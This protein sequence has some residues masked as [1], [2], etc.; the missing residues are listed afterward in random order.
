MKSTTRSAAIARRVA[1]ALVA[2]AMLGASLV[3]CSSG[4]TTSSSERIRRRGR[5]RRRAGRS[6]TGRGPRPPRPR[7]RRS[8]RRT[9]RST[10][11]S[12]TPA[13]TRP[14]T[15]S[16]R[17]RSR[18][19]RVRPTSRRSSTTPSRSSRSASRSSTSSST[20]ST[21]LKS[22]YTPGPWS[23]VNVGGQLYGLPQDS[24]PMAHV[25][26]QDGLRQVRPHRAEDLGRVRGRRE[27]AARGRPRRKYIT[28]DSGDA[29]FTT[30]MIWQA[31]GRPF[32]A[33]GTKVSDQPAGRRAPRSGPSTWNQLVEGKLLSTIPGWSDDWYKAL[34][35]GDDR[36]ARHRRLDARRARVARQGRLR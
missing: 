13:R 26:Q 23:A 18:P 25:L 19:A 35:N 12:S 10:S 1:T 2:S 4:S 15:R 29:G 5:T 17:T 24:G 3:A 9:R 11:S 8:R 27:E 28:S 7:S 30:S 36:D 33:D 31:G 34:G 32:S 6:P 20:A 16:C 22:D 21:R 14:S